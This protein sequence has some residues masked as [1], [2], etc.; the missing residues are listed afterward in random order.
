MKLKTKTATVN[1][2]RVRY[3]HGGRGKPLLFLHG[4]PAQPPT[5]GHALELLAEHFT[6]YAPYMFDFDCASIT[7]TSECVN[8]AISEL[9]I[10]NAVVVGISFGG[11]VAGLLSQDKKLVSRL[12]L[13]NTAG[14]PRGASFARMLAN[15]LRSSLLMLMNGKA[16]HFF[17]RYASSA[18]FLASLRTVRGRKLFDEVRK[19]AKTHA[20]YLFQQIRVPTTIMWC[21]HDDVFTVS[22]AAILQKMIKKS[23]LIIVDG[24]HYWPFHKPRHFA[25]TVLKSFKS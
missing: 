18:A 24:D 2:R 3:L 13:I 7:E 20:C 23:E 4:W 14:V 9:G 10:R 5:Y 25:E 6:V 8:A 12:V 11:A 17:H 1:G 22:N 21:R 15:L 16:S 19:S